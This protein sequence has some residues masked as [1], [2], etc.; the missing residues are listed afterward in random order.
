MKLWSQVPCKCIFQQSHLTSDKGVEDYIFGNWFHLKYFTFWWKLNK[1][2]YFLDRNINHF[3][4]V[5]SVFL[6]Y[7]R[8][9]F[10]YSFLRIL[11]L[12]L[13]SWIKHYIRGRKSYR[14]KLSKLIVARKI[15]ATFLWLLL[16]GT[17][18]FPDWL[19]LF[20]KKKFF[21]VFFPQ[22]L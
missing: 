3:I 17:I 7:L 21:L 15:F 14:K 5:F 18:F 11:W 1:N 2:K 20:P 8:I 22:K 4:W 19:Q 10:I 9:K 16:P 6:T 12:F 13:V